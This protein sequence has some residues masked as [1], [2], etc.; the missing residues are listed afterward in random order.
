MYKRIEH[1]KLC[2]KVCS[3]SEQPTIFNIY[4]YKVIY[5]LPKWNFG[6]IKYALLFT[7]STAEKFSLKEKTTV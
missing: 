7:L 4:I 3:Q 1:G 2:H 5:I 6:C